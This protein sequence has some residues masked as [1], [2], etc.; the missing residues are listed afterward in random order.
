MIMRNKQIHSW[1]KSLSR[2]QNF[3]VYFEINI[4][5]NINVTICQYK[6]TNMFKVVSVIRKTSIILIELMNI[7]LK[8]KNTI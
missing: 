5:T 8:T 1:L 6:F 7:D 4:N 3:N 2:S